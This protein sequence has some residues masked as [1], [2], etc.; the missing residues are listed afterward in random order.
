ML[1]RA[2]KR[3]NKC[4]I[5]G[6]FL[7]SLRS[8]PG[9]PTYVLP[10]F[11]SSFKDSQGV[12]WARDSSFPSDILWTRLTAKSL[13]RWAWVKRDFLLLSLFS[14]DA[15][16]ALGR[17]RDVFF[18]NPFS[19]AC[20]IHYFQARIVILFII[21]SNPVECAPGESH[22]YYTALWVSSGIW[23]AAFLLCKQIH[24]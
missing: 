17:V 18:P 6:W 19:S 5:S 9:G 4:S 8:P 2:V 21:S 1:L 11:Q 7:K 22:S 10:T 15:A 13:D 14:P 20:S 3:P 23:A 16:C 12:P 24:I